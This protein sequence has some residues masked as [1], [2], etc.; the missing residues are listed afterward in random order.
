MEVAFWTEG[1][2]QWGG[3]LNMQL[4][5]LDRG[6][7]KN[8][9][10]ICAESPQTCIIC[11]L[12]KQGKLHKNKT[13]FKTWDVAIIRTSGHPSQW[14][15]LLWTLTFFWVSKPDL[16]Q[17]HQ[18]AHRGETKSPIHFLLALKIC[19]PTPQIL[20]YAAL[21]WNCPIWEN[22]ESHRYSWALMFFFSCGVE[23]S[24]GPAICRFTLPPSSNCLL[25]LFP[26]PLW[27]IAPSHPVGTEAQTHTLKLFNTSAL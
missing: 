2:S 18:L 22:I 7:W 26:Q 15:D 14:V 16:E 3:N 13:T 20:M 17:V 11:T 19:T 23:I 5:R 12:P 1:W 27:V 9:N 6:R 21:K 10:E 8:K 4:A 25:C 24:F